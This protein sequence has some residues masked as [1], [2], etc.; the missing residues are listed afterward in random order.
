MTRHIFRTIDELFRPNN[1]KYISLEDNISIKKLAKVD[2]RWSTTKNSPRV[3]NINDQP[4]PHL[5]TNTKVQ[6]LFSLGDHPPTG[7]TNFQAEM[8][9]YIGSAAKCRSIHPGIGGNV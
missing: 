6:A 4:G 7:Q 1:A 9:L 5:A 2:A 8:V 3:G